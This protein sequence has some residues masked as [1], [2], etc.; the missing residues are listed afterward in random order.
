MRTSRRQKCFTRKSFLLFDELFKSTKDCFC[1]IDYD[2]C[3][4][5][6][7]YSKLLFYLHLPLSL[8]EWI[9]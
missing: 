6:E 3:L 4:N 9:C 8:N 5:V 1:W 7:E 2:H